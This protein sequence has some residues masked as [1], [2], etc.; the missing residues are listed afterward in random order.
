MFVWYYL[1]R[2]TGQLTIFKYYYK[3]FLYRQTKCHDE[4]RLD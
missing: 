1:I 2:N 3:S 4:W